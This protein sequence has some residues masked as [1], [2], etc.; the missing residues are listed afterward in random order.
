MTHAERREQA[1]MMCEAAMAFV[2]ARSL[3]PPAPLLFLAPKPLAG[4]DDEADA[5]VLGTATPQTTADMAR[6]LVRSERAAVAALAV[7]CVGAEVPTDPSRWSAV[8]RAVHEGHAPPDDHPNATE[9]ILIVAQADG[10]PSV[11]RCVRVTRTADGPNYVDE[12]PF[13]PAA[14]MFLPLYVGVGVAT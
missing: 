12:H 7:G 10:G 1:E 13:A 8:D 9:H 3:P 5:T 14:H 11:T 2:R 4:V 6:L